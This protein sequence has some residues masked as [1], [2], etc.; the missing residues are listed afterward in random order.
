MY[1]RMRSR[2]RN[3]MPVAGGRGEDG[4]SD[5]VPAG[6]PRMHQSPMCSVNG[7][8]GPGGLWGDRGQ[9]A[10][11]RKSD[12]D[13][14]KGGRGGPVGTPPTTTVGGRGGGGGGAR[15]KGPSHSLRSGNAPRRCFQ[16]P[17]GFPTQ[18]ERKNC[19]SSSDGSDP[20]PSLRSGLAQG[21]RLETPHW[22]EMG[23]KST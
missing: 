10:W 20:D 4:S 22:V 23:T 16:R 17:E 18:W 12:G 8:R 6:S 15:G 7:K 19:L 9:H 1:V 13:I 3:D 2:G 11:E 21:V 5:K 14:G